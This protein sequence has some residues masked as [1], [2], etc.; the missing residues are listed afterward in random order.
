MDQTQISKIGVDN[1][2]QTS[3]KF[4]TRAVSRLA[5]VIAV[6][7]I[8]VVAGV[9]GYF[10]LYQPGPTAPTVATTPGPTTLVVDKANEL[11]SLDPAFDYEYAGW[12]V[13]ANLYDQLVT[14][15]LLY[16]SDAAD[17]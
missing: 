15:C 7:V 5:A 2:M 4:S 12:E 9:A 16:T 6:I 1:E 3:G 11:Q 14:Y 17:E 10:L 13:I 8:I